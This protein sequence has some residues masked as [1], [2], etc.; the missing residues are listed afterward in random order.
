MQKHI[1]TNKQNDRL[2]SLD[3]LR[4]F[5][6]LWIIGGG[7]FIVAL[8][9]A[10]DWGWL[11]VIAEQ[12]EHVRWDGFHFE[13]LIFPLFMFISGVAIPYAITSKIEK[14]TDKFSLLK[15]A[16]KRGITLVLLGIMYNGALAR[17][18]G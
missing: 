10:V 15:K 13:D 17:G 2:A 1:Q 5:D 8:S 7:S 11:N 14:G 9:K 4:G 18:F 6:M 3:V 12:M 16:A